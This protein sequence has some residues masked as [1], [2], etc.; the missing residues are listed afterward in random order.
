MR[1]LGPGFATDTDKIDDRRTGFPLAQ[2]R[3]EYREVVVDP[4]M[5][6]FVV[7]DGQVV[8]FQGADAGGD[9]PLFRPDEEE[10]FAVSCV[11]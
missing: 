11:E 4:Q 3:R 6:D 2:R 5:P 10:Q 1:G 8:F 7:E 9:G